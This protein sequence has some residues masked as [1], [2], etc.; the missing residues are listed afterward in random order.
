[1]LEMG[2]KAGTAG[3][4]HHKVRYFLSEWPWLTLP[5]TLVATWAVGLPFLGRGREERP[6]I[7]FPWFWA[8]GNFLMF[9]LWS[10]AKPNYY[11]PC[12]PG[13]ALLVGLAWV[14]IL[15]T[16]RGAYGTAIMHARA[17]RFLQLHWL[18]LIAL[19][20]AAPLLADRYAA[21]L[22]PTIRPWIFASSAAVVV[23]VAL[24]VWAW[25][26]G[27]ESGVL[28]A[29]VG[30]MTVAVTI[31]Y[32]AIV[33]Q[34]NQARS[35]R[36]LAAKL[37]R[38]LPRDARTVMFYRELDEGLWFYLKGRTLAAV[39]GSAPKYNK[40][41]EFAEAD[42]EDRLIYDN[43][44]RMRLER[45]VLVDWLEGAKHES[46]YVLIR[47]KVYDLFN[48][49][50]EDLADPIFREP[51]LDRHALVL[52]RVRDRGAVA[53]GTAAGGQRAEARR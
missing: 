46:P 10:V 8:V 18:G 35:H 15:Q 12:E 40:G 9:C 43:A 34:F 26:R 48:P 38:V 41:F 20:V 52:L 50:L 25:R 17:R 21:Q 13:V 49:G 36:D 1:M 44:K 28:A 4:T 19:A 14:R 51:E 37:D 33:P 45:Q 32:A 53:A 24:S 27:A 23:G 31:G 22:A 6:T 3:I 16:A 7:W 5:W 11:V 39:P 30:G 47:A 2:Q 29:L 42:R